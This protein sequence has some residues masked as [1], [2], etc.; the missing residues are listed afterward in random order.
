MFTTATIEENSKSLLNVRTVGE[1]WKPSAVLKG[2]AENYMPLTAHRLPDLD[3]K[4]R[5]LCRCSC[6]V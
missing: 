3:V 6:Y 2:D 1:V 4:A 5:C